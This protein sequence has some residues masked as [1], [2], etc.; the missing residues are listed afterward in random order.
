MSFTQTKDADGRH[1]VRRCDGC[2]QASRSLWDK[3]NAAWA[4]AHSCVTPSQLASTPQRDGRR[5]VTR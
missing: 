1:L 3:V 2:G 5:D 4:L